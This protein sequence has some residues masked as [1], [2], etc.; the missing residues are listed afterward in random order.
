MD[1]GAWQAR[2]HR[3]AESQIKAF[4]TES[5]SSSVFYQLCDLGHAA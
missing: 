1:R 2:V 3:V 5:D 4:S